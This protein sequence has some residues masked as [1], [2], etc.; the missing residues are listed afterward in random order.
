MS[1]AK[2]LL[3]DMKNLAS[4]SAISEVYRP[5]D[6]FVGGP[7]NGHTFFAM[8]LLQQMNPKIFVELGTHFGESYFSVCQSVS[9]N[10][11]DT[12]CYAVDTW[13][14]DHQAGFYTDNVYQSVSKINDEK[15]RD[16]S[17]LM[18]MTFDQALGEFEQHS[19]DLLHIDGLHTYEAVKHDFETWRSKVTPG[20]IVLFHDTQIFREDFGVWKYWKEITEQYK[21]TFE[22]KH[23]CGLGVLRMPGELQREETMLEK[24]LFGGHV[25]ADWLARS[26]ASRS[27]SNLM[28]RFFEKCR[29][30]NAIESGL[31][32][33]DRLQARLQ[34]IESSRV[35]KIAAKLSKLLRRK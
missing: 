23:S 4:N 30:K 7:W 26:Y 13:Q 3:L 14:G 1:Q 27:D 24:M 6:Y 18:R 11:L 22:F 19:I 34:L 32:E 2:N 17:F 12:R 9:Q 21:D 29:Q 20:G 31:Q 35:Y 28:H 8:D 33:L 15:Y 10:K 16:F 25:N 5:C